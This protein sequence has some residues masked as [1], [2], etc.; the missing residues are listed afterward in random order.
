M[1]KVYRCICG[2]VQLRPY[3]RCHHGRNRLVRSGVWLGCADR[4]ERILHQLREVF[5]DE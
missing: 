5:K 4:P 1:K 2:R 3:K